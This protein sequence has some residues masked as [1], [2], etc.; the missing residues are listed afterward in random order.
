MRI[1]GMACE[2]RKIPVIIHNAAPQKGISTV[3]R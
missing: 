3:S 1:L 2:A